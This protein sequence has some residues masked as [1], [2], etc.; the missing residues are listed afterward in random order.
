MA[1]LKQRG[2]IIDTLSGI[3]TFTLRS[4]VSIGFPCGHLCVSRRTRGCG[5]NV[6]CERR[7]NLGQRDLQWRSGLQ[8]GLLGDDETRHRRDGRPVIAV[9]EHE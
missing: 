3:V 6:R 5:R 1:D 9:R 8:G 7:A 2:S 4:S